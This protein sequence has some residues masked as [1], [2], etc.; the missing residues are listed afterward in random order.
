MAAT[1]TSP[2]GIL[3]L[4]Y[5]P[6]LLRIAPVRVGSI[7]GGLSGRWEGYAALLGTPLATE[8]VN[9]VC[10]APDRWTWVQRVTIPNRPVNGVPQPAEVAEKRQELYT[11]G[12]RN[13]L[14]TQVPP[15]PLTREQRQ[16]ALRYEAVV[17]PDAHTRRLWD[18][19]HPVVFMVSVPVTDHAALRAALVP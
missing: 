10:C 16:T 17:S 14:L 7:S 11:S 12:V 5:L 4:A 3:A 15:A 18:G 6:A 2:A 13:V 19:L 9:V 8:Y 1:D